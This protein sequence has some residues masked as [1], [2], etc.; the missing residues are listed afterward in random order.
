MIDIIIDSIVEIE[1]A[2][3][4][5]TYFYDLEEDIDNFTIMANY[6]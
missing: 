4:G 6:E 1:D 3:S 5:D 2:I